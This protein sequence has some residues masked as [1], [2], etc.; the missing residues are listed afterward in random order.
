[1]HE[2]NG[3][4][5]VCVRQKPT[6]SGLTN[7]LEL[8]WA[9]QAAIARKDLASKLHVDESQ[10]IIAAAR[11]TTWTD[12]SLGCPEP[13]VEYDEVRAEGFVLTMRYGGRNFSYHTDLDRVI[14]CPPITED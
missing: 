3:R 14:A 5:F 11:A 8:V 9:P 2:A 10:I 6:V 4:A 13:G 7:K 1:M 12:T